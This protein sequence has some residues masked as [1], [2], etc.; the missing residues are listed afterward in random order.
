[1]SRAAGS[2]MAGANQTMSLFT[3]LHSPGQWV[4]GFAQWWSGALRFSPEHW[5][6]MWNGKKEMLPLAKAVFKGNPPR[7]SWQE[8]PS[9]RWLRL[10]LCGDSRQAATLAK[11]LAAVIGMW[12]FTCF[13]SKHERSSCCSLFGFKKSLTRVCKSGEYI[14]VRFAGQIPYWGPWYNSAAGQNLCFDYVASP[15]FPFPSKNAGPAAR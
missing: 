4:P 5:R 9:L 1:M 2:S 10:P 8:R 3:E 14:Y 15:L 12:L 6:S 7:T 11:L 13:G